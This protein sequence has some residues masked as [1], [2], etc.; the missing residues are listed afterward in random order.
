MP[1]ANAKRQTDLCI[2]HV[3]SLSALRCLKE[4]Q[5]SGHLLDYSSLKTSSHLVPLM[6][7]LLN[8]DKEHLPAPSWES[9]WEPRLL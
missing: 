6:S 8:P 7:L 4:R 3:Q 2:S 1:G 9:Q 5:L